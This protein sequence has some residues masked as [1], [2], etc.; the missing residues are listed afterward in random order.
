MVK[1]PLLRV[2]CNQPKYVSNRDAQV[3]LLPGCKNYLAR[4]TTYITG[5][6]R[7]NKYNNSKIDI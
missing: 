7:L 3:G 2:F 6:V 5:E 4:L 1:S